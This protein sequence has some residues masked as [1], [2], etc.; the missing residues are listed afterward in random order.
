MNTTILIF[1]S[2]LFTFVSGLNFQIGVMG[3]GRLNFLKKRLK[4]LHA[5]GDQQPYVHEVNQLITGK[6]RH[7]LGLRMGAPAFLPLGLALIKGAP[8]IA[9]T[10]IT[11]WAITH[12]LGTIHRSSRSQ[13]KR[14][15]PTLPWEFNPGEVLLLVIRTLIKRPDQLNQELLIRFRHH[16]NP[17]IKR[18]TIYQLTLV[19]YPWASRVLTHTLPEQPRSRYLLPAKDPKGTPIRYQHWEDLM[20]D[21]DANIRQKYLPLVMLLGPTTR[22]KWIEK[23]SED[24][25]EEVREQARDLKWRS[26]AAEWITDLLEE[27]ARSTDP[28]EKKC[29]QKWVELVESSDEATFAALS[30][31]FSKGAAELRKAEACKEEEEEI[32]IVARKLAEMPGKAADQALIQLLGNPNETVAQV[33]F[34]ILETRQS[35]TPE[36]LEWGMSNGNQKVIYTLPELARRFEWGAVEILVDEWLESKDV[37]LRVAALKALGNWDTQHAVLDRLLDQLKSPNRVVR[38][39]VLED[40]DNNGSP[41]V[42]DLLMDA[43]K[44]HYQSYPLAPEYETN[45]DEATYIE[46]IVGKVENLAGGKEGLAWL[47]CT[48]CLTRA[49]THKVHGVL[50]SLC[51]KCKRSRY[52]IPRIYEVVGQIGPEQQEGPGPN[53]SYLV[54]LWDPQK[55]QARYL[56][57]DT[58]E[59][60]GG[61]NFNYDWAVNAVLETQQNGSPMNPWKVSVRIKNDPPLHKNSLKLIQQVTK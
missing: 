7:W 16:E 13:F 22:R 4:K 31:V 34:E 57:I 61:G 17:E 46:R 58:L 20:E 14:G 33:A 6:K 51:S 43:L 56:E 19:P 1:L 10:G 30:L 23:A 15:R 50:F 12:F 54:W 3:A 28:E 53:G 42:L 21:A 38:S 55:E 2:S 5:A 49:A 59:V 29:F 60:I 27:A 35:L 25:A 40:L 9:L 44:N 8:S 47:F 37:Y 36:D 18:M 39:Q 11:V 24:P 41:Q 45:P 48:R 32:V 26:A 52:L